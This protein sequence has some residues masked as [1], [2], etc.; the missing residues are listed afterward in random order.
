MIRAAMS[1]FTGE[2]SGLVDTFSKNAGVAKQLDMMKKKADE[3][4]ARQKEARRKNQRKI[5]LIA[6]AVVLV[7]AAGVAV[8]A[9]QKNAKEKAATEY[10]AQPEW[11]RLQDSYEV[12]DP[13]DQATRMA[14]REQVVA[15]MLADGESSAAEEFFFTNSQGQLGDVDCAT[16]IARYYKDA[17]DT[18]ALRAFTGK[19]KLRYDSDTK[20]VRNIR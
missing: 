11:V 18:E 8:L 16:L 3:A 9:V 20:K 6:L 15:A 1:V 14:L 7:F 17:G 13:A 5:L 2:A 10:A 12:S 4:L 19:L